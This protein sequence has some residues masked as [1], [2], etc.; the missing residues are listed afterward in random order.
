MIQPQILVPSLSYQNHLHCSP[1]TLTHTLKLFKHSNLLPLNQ[2]HIMYHLILWSTSV[3]LHIRDTYANRHTH[4]DWLW[5][6]GC[7]LIMRS[8]WGD[9]EQRNTL[10]RKQVSS[11]GLVRQL[12][13]WQWLRVFAR[14]HVGGKWTTMRD[15]LWFIGTYQVSSF[16]NLHALEIIQVRRRLEKSTFGH[17][18]F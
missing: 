10:N 16:L 8:Q 2:M 14:M 17:F 6:G 1:Q 9:R 5:S 11:P 12:H 18:F 13:L 7:P 15:S 3:R 4:I